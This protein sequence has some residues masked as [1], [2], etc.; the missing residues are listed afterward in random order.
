MPYST[1]EM[2]RKAFV[3]S[4]DGTLPATQTFTAADLTDDQLL[5]A[6]GEADGYID[7]MIGRFY[8]TP[9][10]QTGNTAPHPLDWWSR[11]IAAY[12]AYLAFRQGQDFSDQD[13][14]ARRYQATL[15]ALQ[16]VNAGTA[17]LNLP[18]QDG[19]SR[20]SGA[21]PAYEPYQ[22][23]LWTPED[24]SVNPS[25]GLTYGHQPFWRS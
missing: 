14:V 6:I 4:S 10:A 18:R 22:G 9:V 20:A 25:W 21:S 16:A 8:T 15:V 13:P 5:D 24:F 7:S 3:P 1:P 23:D 2:V 11:N 19:D 12:N 17:S